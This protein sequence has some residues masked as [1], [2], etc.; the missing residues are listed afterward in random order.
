MT[1]DL[2]FRLSRSSDF[3]EILKNEDDYRL[4]SPRFHAWIKMEHLHAML[5]CV[6]GAR[7]GKGRGIRKASAERKGWGRGGGAAL[8]LKRAPDF[9]FLEPAQQANVML[10]YSGDKLTNL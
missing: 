10:A 4:T 5:A 6:A 3:D 8:A 1:Q 7:R 2:T 9:P